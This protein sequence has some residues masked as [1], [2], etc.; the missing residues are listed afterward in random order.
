MKNSTTIRL[1]YWAKSHP[2]SAI[3]M[4]TVSKIVIGSIALFL[5]ISANFE[6]LTM[7]SKIGGY[8]F[9]IIAAVC[10]MA[11]PPKRLKKKLGFASFYQYQK[12]MDAC[13][14]AFGFAF[15]FFVGNLMP[16]WVAQ[17]AISVTSSIRVPTV[18]SI[19]GQPKPAQQAPATER[20]GIFHKWLIKKAKFKIK[21]VI[22]KIEQLEG[23][24]LEVPIKIFLTLL[25][26]AL[27]FG[28]G[29]LA[30]AF[31]CNLSCSGQETL[32]AIVMI[33]GPLLVLFLGI[34]AIREIWKKKK[35]KATTP[36]N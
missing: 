14:V 18:L 32:G 34:L 26:L 6:G 10:I 7:D 2:A 4:I 31:G 20:G 16:N 3:L 33:G 27:I 19:V 29:Y 17:P 24:D 11:Y 28:L 12:R 35:K 23:D 36:V 25:F 21:R 5:G 22:E 9:G 8:V 15:F 30:L 13:L 1:S